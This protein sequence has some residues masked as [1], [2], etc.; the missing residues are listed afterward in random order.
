MKSKPV[1]KIPEAPSSIQKGVPLKQVLGEQ[2]VLQ[3]AQNLNLVYPEFKQKDFIQIVLK[4]FEYLS[5]TDRSR[6]IAKCL[7]LYLPSNYS[8]AIEVLLNSLTRPLNKTHGNGLAP[9]FYM[10]H[11]HFVAEY[12]LDANYNA[13]NDPFELSMKAQYELTKRF[14][15]EYSIRPFLEADLPRTL[16]VMEKWCMDPDPHVR[17]LCSEGTR[18]RL[19]WAPKIS[20]LVKSPEPVLFILECLKNDVD[21]YVRRSVANH[22]GDIAKDHLEL[23]LDL[24]EKWLVNASKELK[25]V[26]RHALRNPVKKGNNRAINLRKLA[27]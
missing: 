25:W 15:C 9:M 23:A 18:P 5:L 2:T 10:P 6:F 14:T 3:L 13:G 20:A 4:D 27:K 12:G 22:V 19:P 7:K 11:C 21:L 16:G 24:C 17:R 1:L 8:Q 26:I